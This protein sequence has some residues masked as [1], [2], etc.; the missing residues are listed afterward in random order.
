MKHYFWQRWSIEPQTIGEHRIEGRRAITDQGQILIKF[1]DPDGDWDKVCLVS[2][3]AEF[4]RG[5]G[6]MVECPIRDAN[7]ELICNALNATL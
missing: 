1:G 6:H 7:A 4:K 3:H 2:P 5:Q